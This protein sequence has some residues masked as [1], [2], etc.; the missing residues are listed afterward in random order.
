[1]FEFF[2]FPEV[3]EFMVTF[4]K[5]LSYSFADDRGFY[6]IGEFVFLGGG[7]KEVS[8]RFKR[9]LFLFLE[10]LFCTGFYGVGKA[11]VLLFL[12]FYCVA[13]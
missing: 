10:C 2:G 4:L 1:M 7:K 3:Y 11:F 6:L 13:D 8:G 12:G 5:N 9:H